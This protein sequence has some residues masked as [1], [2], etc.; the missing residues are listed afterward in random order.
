MR[1]TTTLSSFLLSLLA[2]GT[3]TVTNAEKCAC[4]GGTD[5]SKT[6]CDRIGAKYGV[7]GCGFTGCCV[8]PGTQ[9]N[10]FVQACKD[11]GYGFKR[12]DDCGTC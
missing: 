11:L 7:F 8:N 3:V 6:A 12:C 1:L 10:K 4:N 2:V 5:H 9:H